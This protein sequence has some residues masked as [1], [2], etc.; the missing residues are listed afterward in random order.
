M[1]SGTMGQGRPSVWLMMLL[2][3]LM[4]AQAPSG[5]AEDTE[6]SSASGQFGPITPEHTLWRIASENLPD[7][8]VSIYQYMLALVEANPHAF[9]NGNANLMRSGV[10]LQLP[11]VEAAS[12]VTTEQAR[13]LL[14]QQNE[15]L[16][17]LSPEEIR[18]VRLGELPAAPTQIDPEPIP[19]PEPDSEGEPAIEP[20]LPDEVILEPDLSETA[21][22]Q[23]DDVGE[24]VAEASWQAELEALLDA[25]ADV[26]AN[27]EPARIDEP[28]VTAPAEPLASTAP[29]P[30]D[31]ASSHFS[32]GLPRAGLIGLMAL[33]VLA[34]LAFVW[35]RRSRSTDVPATE[36]IP[37]AASTATRTAG[38]TAVDSEALATGTIDDAD[39]ADGQHETPGQASEQEFSLPEKPAPAEPDTNSPDMQRPDSPADSK[40]AE[41][42]QE[43]DD[44]WATLEASVLDSASPDEGSEDTDGLHPESLESADD[45]PGSKGSDT[46][47]EDAPEPTIK[48]DTVDD[49]DRADPEPVDELVLSSDLVAEL[50]AEGEPYTDLADEELDLDFSFS[51]EAED[52]T[53]ADGNS[54]PAVDHAPESE[55]RKAV[56]LSDRMSDTDA[57]ISLDLARAMA[58]S[59]D[60]DYAR[61][62]LDEIIAK[63]SD[64]MAARAREIRDALNG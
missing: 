57:E 56:E 18:A 44:A 63:A 21:A 38:V 24:P 25:D 13:Q 48:E 4:M 19:V 2:V 15:W 34:G 40:Q 9:I 31:L 39:E 8:T 55:S 49:F 61:E 6:H 64:P 50:D 46:Q 47:A 7:Q 59:S 20:A 52:G 42:E 14:Q 1:K 12:T 33:L 17:A 60:A 58:N 26:D 43:D 5:L 30:T 53:R 11:T 3:S 16:A 36:A 10:I 22:P 41:A 45:R 51:S 32:D 29:E 27:S 23:S 37:A 35:L 54:E 28:E 62:L